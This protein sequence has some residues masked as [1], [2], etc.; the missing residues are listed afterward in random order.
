[1]MSTQFVNQL[2]EKANRPLIQ[3]IAGYIVASRTG[4]DPM[5]GALFGLVHAA[6]ADATAPFFKAA[7]ERVGASNDA[8]FVGRTI[9]FISSIALTLSVCALFGFHLTIANGLTLIASQAVVNMLLQNPNIDL[10]SLFRD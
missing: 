10:A 2:S 8:K 3:G 7:F 5:G 1:M 4:L 9:H 6:I